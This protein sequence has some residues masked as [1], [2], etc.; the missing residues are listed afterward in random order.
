MFCF[1][2]KWFISGAI[3]TGKKAPGFVL[4][5][6]KRC[7]SCTG[8]A[9]TADSLTD[10]L[11]RDT[12]EIL[13]PSLH[14]HEP[15]VE[16][17]MSSLAPSPGPGRGRLPGSGSR[18]FSFGPVFAAV[19]A[20]LVISAGVWWFFAPGTAPEKAEQTFLSDTGSVIRLPEAPLL[21]LAAA[22]ESPLTNEIRSLEE[23]AKSTADFFISNLDMDI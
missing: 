14:A 22:V 16:R 4:S 6:L 15:A 3:D 8:F 17:I 7:P 19:F 12:D 11:K 21:E 18:R 13:D 23:A 9:N 5:H 2:H 1:I 10:M 20:T